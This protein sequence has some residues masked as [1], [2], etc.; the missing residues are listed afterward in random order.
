MKKALIN[1]LRK[2]GIMV[3]RYSPRNSDEALLSFMLQH[4]NIDL[5]MDIGGNSGQFAGH[6]RKMGY[7]GKIIS[8]EPLSKVF[9]QLAQNAAP[10]PN[11]E[12]HNLAIGREA[13]ESVINVSENTYSSS[14]LGM[15]QTHQ[16]AAETSR[17]VAS[18]TIKVVP[19]GSV[20]TKELLQ[21]H[22]SV[23]VKVDVQGFEREVIEGA[24]E[25]LP[26]VT[27]VE[28]ELSM[29]PL[30][31]NGPLYR[32]LI[33]R[34]EELGFGLFNMAPEFRDPETHRLLQTNGLFVHQKA[35]K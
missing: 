3:Q 19:L 23:F 16:E 22:R 25:Q 27:M 26:Q 20:L 31:E 7:T 2:R 34:M 29:V 28:L 17:Y 1:L 10:D 24:L 21:K 14:L 32:E 35:L 30:Y 5:V 8:C 12:V 15:H 6:L 33:D 18:E 11:W 4:H 13:G 9:A